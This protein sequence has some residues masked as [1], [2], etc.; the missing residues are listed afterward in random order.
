MNK[1]G[2]Y[3]VLATSLFA[4]N[5][6]F[7]ECKKTLMGVDCEVNANGVSSHMRGNAVENAKAAKELKA[8]QAKAKRDAKAIAEAQTKK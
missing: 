1:M 3:V 8:A 7:A 2:L 4:T 5:V 6:A